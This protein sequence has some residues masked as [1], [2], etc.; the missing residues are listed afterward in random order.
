MVF[1]DMSL[2]MEPA[3]PTLGWPVLACAAV[4]LAALTVWTYMGVKKATWQRVGIIL[5]LRLLALIVALSALVRPSIAFTRLQGVD[6]TKLL[7]VVD[8]SE[9]MNVADVDGKPSRWEQVNQLWSSRNAQRKLQELQTNEKIEV[10]KYLGDG[11]LRADEPSTAADGKRTDIAAW[12]HELWLK[13]S[14]EKRLRGVVIISDGADNGTKYSLQEKSRQW[15]GITPLHAF[16]VGDPANAKYSKDIGLTSVRAG[17]SVIPAGTKFTV[18][19]MVQA[20]GFKGTDIQASVFMQDVN[21]KDK[22]P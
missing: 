20:P 8:A 3:L 2:A 11:G 9:S 19:A 10:V 14:Q 21:A 4:A 13:H 12:L 17:D 6:I 18:T 7:V 16:G 22:A 5:G 15:R 1:A